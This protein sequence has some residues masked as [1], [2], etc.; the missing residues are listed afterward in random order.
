MTNMAVSSLK[1]TLNERDINGRK[2]VRDRKITGKGDTMEYMRE[3]R[4][5]EET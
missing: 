1:R 2:T 5:R 4:K 3:W